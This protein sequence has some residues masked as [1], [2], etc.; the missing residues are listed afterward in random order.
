MVI[1]IDGIIEKFDA[2]LVLFLDFSYYHTYVETP[3]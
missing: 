1:Y 3:R 2:S